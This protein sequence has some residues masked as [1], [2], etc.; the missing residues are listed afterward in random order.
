M[1]CA[2]G[3]R[4]HAHE[5]CRFVAA[6][7]APAGSGRMDCR[8]PG[9]IVPGRVISR[10]V[11][12]FAAA[13]PNGNSRDM[14]SRLA[15]GTHIVVAGGAIGRA[16]IVVEYGACPSDGRMTHA[17]VKIGNYMGR[18]FA[19]DRAARVMTADATAHNFVVTE[20]DSRIPCHGRMTRQTIV[21]GENVVG[22]LG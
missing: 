14:S 7:A 21:G 13:G 20:V 1:R 8:N 19:T 2:R 4:H 9:D 6:L 11:A 15:L 5:L 10:G 3:A 17:A 12:A 22:G 16:S 18:A